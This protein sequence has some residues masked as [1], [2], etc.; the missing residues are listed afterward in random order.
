MIP[1]YII[2]WNN[3]T[4]VSSFIKQLEKLDNPIVIV[5]NNSSYKPLKEF[6]TTIEKDSSNISVLLLDQNYGHMVN[7]KRS[8][9]F[10]EVYILSDP[11]LLLNQNL[12]KDCVQHLFRISQKYQSPKVGLALDLSDHQNFIKGSYGRLVYQIE[13]KYYQNIIP[14]SEYQLYQA[15]TDTTF[16][17]INRRYPENGKKIRVGGD[18]TAKHLPWYDN[19]LKN[20][21]PKDELKEWLKN[22]KSSSILDYID[23]DELLS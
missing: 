16:C 23:K 8:D 19:Y 22:N 15:P 2:A 1:I 7:Q 4:F 6:Y 12:P 13:S 17:L 10:P 3:L 18:F 21:I 5:D 20:N 11:D 14:D 9:L